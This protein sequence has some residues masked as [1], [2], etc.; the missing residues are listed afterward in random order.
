MENEIDFSKY[1]LNDLYSS[2]ESID[3][4]QFPDRARMIDKLILQKEAEEASTKESETT[5]VDP[6]LASR[7]HRFAAAVVDAIIAII[8]TIPVMFYI[9]FDKLED[10]EFSVI[11]ALFLYGVVITFIIHG[12]LLY[13]YAQTI[14]KHY[15][16]IRIE[17]LDGEKAPLNR[18]FFLRM[19]PM[20]LI[21][22][23]PSVGNVIAGLVNPLFIFGR[24]KRCL[25]DYIAST[26][27]CYVD[28]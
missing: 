16:G 11:A 10:P 19:L 5:D 23:I 24:E 7:G 15:M 17:T 1:S 13:Y 12:Y 20:Q 2:A 22:L 9:G 21:G 4:E 3:R 6:S 14:G 27:V 28:K 25:H 8:A 18:I 26:K